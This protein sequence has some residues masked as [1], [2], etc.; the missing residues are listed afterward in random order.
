M[1]WIK[2]M[3]IIKKE[4]IIFINQLNLLNKFWIILLGMNKMKMTSLG[5]ISYIFFKFTKCSEWYGVIVYSL[6]YLFFLFI[7]TFY[8][9]D[10][11]FLKKMTHV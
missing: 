7:S 1:K 4:N 10:I 6:Y 5:C 3:D 8:I 9:W 11:Y 2:L